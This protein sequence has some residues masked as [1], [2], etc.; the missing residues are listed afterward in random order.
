[1]LN[2]L[3]YRAEAAYGEHST[4]APC[5][6]REAYQEYIQAFLAHNSPE[7]VNVFFQGAALTTL[8]AP[9]GEQW[10]KIVLIEYRNLAVFR[11]WAES[12]FYTTEIDPIRKVALADWRLVMTAS[13]AGQDIWALA[14]PVL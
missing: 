4:K 9:A 10:D 12:L 5:S 3:R 11:R 8:V 14:A 2:L 6:G 13:Q 7:E 1:M